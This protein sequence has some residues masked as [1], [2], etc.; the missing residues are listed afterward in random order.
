METSVGSF[1]AFVITY[2]CVKV[3]RTN[4]YFRYR[5][6]I[7]TMIFIIFV[8]ISLSTYTD[9]PP[10]AP[11][12]EQHRRQPD[13]PVRRLA[14]RQPLQL[15]AVFARPLGRH[16]GEP[17]RAPRQHPRPPILQP[18]PEASTP[19]E[20]SGEGQGRHASASHDQ[21]DY[22]QQHHDYGFYYY[23][24]DS[25]SS[26]SNYDDHNHNHTTYNNHYNHDDDHHDSS[27]HDD[28]KREHVAVQQSV[29]NSPR[30]PGLEGEQDDDEEEPVEGRPPGDS[31]GPDVLHDSSTSSSTSSP[32]SA[33]ASGSP[34]SPRRNHDL[35]E[36]EL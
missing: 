30:G 1:C 6:H 22:D 9:F 8:L 31:G 27:T 25:S 2:R 21:E 10:R 34:S 16:S 5:K 24:Y 11:G 15:P 17:A 3:T 32:A 26:A 13:L 4:K 20:A 36:A 14:A 19:L 18:H 7:L 35:L 28:R 23:N 33:T 12:G 29:R